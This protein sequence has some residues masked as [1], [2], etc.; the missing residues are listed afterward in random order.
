VFV[1]RA[2]SEGIGYLLD[3]KLFKSAVIT[4]NFMLHISLHYNSTEIL[5]CNTN[6]AVAKYVSDH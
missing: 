5:V 6:M 2:G 4:R 3:E 1:D